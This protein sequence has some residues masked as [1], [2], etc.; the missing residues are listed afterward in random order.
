MNTPNENQHWLSRTLLRRFKDDGA[1]LQCYQVATNEWMPKSIDRI[2]SAPG[3]N[4]LLTLGTTDNS[5]EAAFSKV[6]SGLPNTLKALEKASKR[7]QSQLADA[8]Y[9]ILGWY[10]A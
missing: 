8:K 4:Q 6:E 1:P 5:L 7:S 9:N 10:C 2:C 3:Y